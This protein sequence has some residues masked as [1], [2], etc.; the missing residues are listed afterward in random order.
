MQSSLVDRI[1]ELE[2]SL[3][4]KIRFYR[5]VSEEEE[6]ERTPIESRISELRETLLGAVERVVAN[7]SEQISLLTDPLSEFQSQI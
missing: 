5:G 7:V 1:E 4:E 2:A 3:Q 6:K